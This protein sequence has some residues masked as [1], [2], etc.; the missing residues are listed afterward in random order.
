MNQ[1]WITVAV[2]GYNESLHFTDFPLSRHFQRLLTAFKY[3]QL[4]VHKFSRLV[5][6]VFSHSRRKSTNFPQ[7]TWKHPFQSRDVQTSLYLDTFIHSLL[8]T[9]KTHYRNTESGKYSDHCI[10][11]I[12]EC[13]VHFML[14]TK[15]DLWVYS[16]F[17]SLTVQAT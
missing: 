4:I 1:E 6:L 2:C 3:S 10:E 13:H 12:D 17:V 14:C 8:Q 5:W 11:R 15:I 7:C 9:N 16:S